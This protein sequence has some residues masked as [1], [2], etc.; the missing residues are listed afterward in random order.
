MVDKNP[1]EMGLGKIVEEIILHIKEE[2]E[3]KDLPVVDTKYK[4]REKRLKTLYHE[5]DRR[6]KLYS[7]DRTYF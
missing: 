2:I 3:L 7:L 1:K 4:S 6:E 5:L